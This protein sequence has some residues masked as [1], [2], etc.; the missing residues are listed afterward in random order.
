MSKQK[1]LLNAQRD[2]KQHYK[3]YKAGKNWLFAG[4]SIAT[5]GSV[6]LFGTGNVKAATTASTDSA[7]EATETATST[8]SELT[9][10]SVA[11]KTSTAATKTTSSA[12]TTATSAA[13]ST[14]TTSS[15][16]TTASSATP[17]STAT[18]TSSAANSSASTKVASSATATSTANSSAAATSTAAASSANT[19]VS[20]SASSAVTTDNTVSS[21]N[22]VS[23]TSAATSSASNSVASKAA[24]SSLSS[25]SATNGDSVATAS[26]AATT[27]TSA[28]VLTQLPKGTTVT[29]SVNGATQFNLPVGADTSAAQRIVAAANLSTPVA[30]TAAD[31]T[32]APDVPNTGSLNGQ[33]P[34]GSDAATSTIDTPDKVKDSFSTVPN[35][36]TVNADGSV[37]LINGAGQNGTY[38]FNNQID[39]T[40]GF[41]IK[42]SFT[43]TATD[44]GGGE[45]IILQPVDPQNAGIN[46][47]TGTLDSSSTY[48]KGQADVGIEGLANTTFIGRDFSNTPSKGD[49]PWN[50]L[51]VRQ[52]DANG[53]MVQPAS[54]SGTDGS[55]QTAAIK[56]GEYYTIIWAPSTDQTGVA[57]GYE[58]G[59]FLYT[60]YSDAAR[61]KQLLTLTTSNIVL[62]K[63][64]SIAAFGASGGKTATITATIESFAGTRVT[65]PVTVHY[66]DQ[67]GNSIAK[68]DIIT[69]NV[70]STL[71]AGA[72]T[73]TANNTDTSG[74]YQAKKVDGY[75]FSTATDPITVANTTNTQ[76]N[77]ITVTYTAAKQTVS[78]TVPTGATAI[79]QAIQSA[80]AGTTNPSVHEYAAVPVTQIPGYTSWVSINGAAAVAQTTISAAASGYDDENDVV[81]YVAN[82]QTATVSV[83]GATSDMT[84]FNY[85]VNGGASQT[86]TYGSAL[87]V[88]Y[89]DVIVVAPITLAGYTNSV[90]AASLTIGT[91]NTVN[92]LAVT[93]AKKTQ[94]ITVNY[95]DYFGNTIK[96]GTTTFTGNYG[97]VDNLTTNA[98]TAV[99]ID[100][101]TL[102]ATDAVNASAAAVSFTLDAD[103]NVIATTAD[104]TPITSITLTYKT[105]VTAKVSGTRV[106]DG[107]DGTDSGATSEQNDYKNLTFVLTDSKGNALDS[108]IDASGVT[109][110]TIY[111]E[112]ADAGNYPDAIII[113]N[114]DLAN[115]KAANPQYNFLSVNSG[116]YRI[117]AAPVTATIT[118]D[119]TAT[120]VYDGT[121][122]SDYVPSVAFARTDNGTLAP[123]EG[124]NTLD[125]IPAWT[126]ADF[127]YSLNGTTVANPTNV[128]T[129]TINFSDAGLAKLAAAKNFAITPV[130]LGTYTITA[131][132]ATAT[133]STPSFAYDGTTKASDETGLFATVAVKA[134]DGD[135]GGSTV[136]V[137]L[138]SDDVTFSTD[139][140]NVGTYNYSLT[141]AG[142]T[143]VQTAV[144]NYTLTNTDATGSVAITA[145]AVDVGIS[146]SSKIYDGTN[147]SYTPTVTLSRADKGTTLPTIDWVAGDFEYAQ[148]G[149]TTTAT[150]NAGDYTIQL[151]AQGQAKLA[152]LTTAGNYTFT[153]TNGDYKITKKPLLLTA[154]VATVKKVYGTKDPT[155]EFNANATPLA[156]GDTLAD[157]GFTATRAS[158]EDIGNYPITSTITD[159]NY[160]YSGLNTNEFTISA[161]PATVSSANQSM[162][163]NGTVPSYTASIKRNDGLKTVVTGA[164]MPT[165]GTLS[166]SDF[167]CVR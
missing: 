56:A 131:A 1:E 151:S 130:Y 21:A 36:N 109:N 39:T 67:N 139:G 58:K 123:N 121:A 26:S 69:V 61:T 40:S 134:G 59:T 17:A 97:D 163:V 70:G 93:Y 138:T 2:I 132:N 148:N 160:N 72:N 94:T 8:A 95:V 50:A 162:T 87:N 142:L 52:T 161:A 111:Y 41:T 100:G 22:T 37:T 116:D 144:K 35:T 16:S 54:Q 42:G 63:A 65:E 85:T 165:T 3:M 6:L 34:A 90:S 89:G 14:T 64:S 66:V 20:S 141:A 112:S 124:T 79:P 127:T 96:T 143:A 155:L 117:T 125:Q 10:Q 44:A 167:G 43:S 45:G 166:N 13:S 149:A 46:D 122:V 119:D 60:T 92:G 18:A 33:N 107:L 31:A 30:V 11:L 28:T 118:S 74:T 113:D 19:A 102:G 137:A 83:T 157:L 15:A 114:K 48:A 5:F 76:L 27:Q 9:A 128:G 78:Y 86:G 164:V 108:N 80:V 77:E 57:T 51:T 133:L 101:Y 81:T 29:T 135:N 68:D 84:T 146:T 154:T 126:A 159:A 55:G 98:S 110:R 24:T 38:V 99:A 136:K 104:G 120:K 82:A 25:Q 71:G 75:T 152:A 23:A 49:T 47:T 145:A 150:R 7:D 73:D 140:A 53:A 105:N 91:D 158:G 4:I 103:G 12:A 88:H 32:T 129:Y 147:I 153:T 106:Y 115:L 62:S 156:T